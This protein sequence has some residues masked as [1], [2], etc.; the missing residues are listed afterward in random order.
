MITL[1][2]I[3]KEDY[4]KLRELEI[5]AAVIRAKYN[6]KEERQIVCFETGGVYPYHT[7]IPAGIDPEVW[8]ATSDDMDAE[9]VRQTRAKN[10]YVV[11]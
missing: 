6:P 9:R 3:T 2:N 5:E 1:H 8:A 4:E 7:D 10:N 11:K